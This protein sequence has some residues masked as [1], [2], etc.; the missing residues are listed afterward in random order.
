MT[1]IDHGVP[2]GI[3]ALQQGI[4]VEGVWISQPNTP[5]PGSPVISARLSPVPSIMGASGKISPPDLAYSYSEPTLSTHSA[6]RTF[7]IPSFS[8]DTWQQHFGTSPDQMYD[9][10]NSDAASSIVYTSTLDA[11]EGRARSNGKTCELI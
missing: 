8:L 2:F 10:P 3:R 11:L 4:E 9:Y 7:R 5:A 1:E 6:G